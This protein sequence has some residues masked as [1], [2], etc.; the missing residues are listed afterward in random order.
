MGLCHYYPGLAGREQ[1]HLFR[2][3]RAPDRVTQSRAVGAGAGRH[4]NEV[5]VAGAT[6]AARVAACTLPV[7]AARTRAAAAVATAVEEEGALASEPRS[8][9]WSRQYGDKATI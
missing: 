4:D 3:P 1:I 9:I 7:A 8:I 5:A 2:R 6:A